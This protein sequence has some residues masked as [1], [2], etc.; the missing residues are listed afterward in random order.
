MSHYS[1]KVQTVP[2]N[3]SP[4][5]PHQQINKSKICQ[6]IALTETNPESYMNPRN[7]A[8]L[9]RALSGEGKKKKKALP[10]Q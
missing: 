9:F 5:P 2:R 3:I 8:T 1:G 7:P 6:E 10:S 4:Y